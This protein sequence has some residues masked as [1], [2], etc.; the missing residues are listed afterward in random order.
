MEIRV[1]RH[2]DELYHWGIKGMRWGIRRYQNKDGSLTSAGLKRY[3]KELDKIKKEK[4]ELDEKAKV[5]ANK[6]KTK[7]KLDELDEMRKQND[8]QKKAL[9]GKTDSDDDKPEEET[10]EQKRER[11]LKSVDAK[12]IYKGKDVLTDA[13]I[14]GRIN[15]IDLE[16]RLSDRIVVEQTKT[17]LDRL[18]SAMDKTATTVDKATN[19]FNKIDKAYSDVAKSAIGK[20]LAKKLG[21]EPPKKEFNLDEAVKNLNKMT[22]QEIKDLADRMKND[23]SIRGVKKSRDKEAAKIKAE[24]DKRAKEAEEASQRL[25]KAQKE[26]DDYNQSI[27]GESP[28]QYSKSGSDITDS[29]TYTKPNDKNTPLLETWEG[30][31]TSRR[32][33]D[34][35]S[36]RNRRP[37][38]IDDDS[39]WEI[40]DDTPISNLQATTTSTG[41]N[42]VRRLF[43]DKHK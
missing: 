30:E 23:E 7:A 9:K 40:V 1:V 10:V 41:R 2:D 25:A 33:S 24:A 12:E 26:V 4:A 37:D 32:T 38:I 16:K 19:M 35:S 17:G 11:L 14:Q 42:A 8:A 5:A 13:E 20:T 39:L 27:R 6:A 21:L 15:R 29:R 18:Q 22:N 36:T 43:K 28:S 3:N 34:S 31:G